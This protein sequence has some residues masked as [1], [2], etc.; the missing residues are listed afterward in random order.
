KTKKTKNTPKNNHQPY[1]Q[2]HK[3]NTTQKKQP[4]KPKHKNK[5]TKK[6]HKIINHKQITHKKKDTNKQLEVKF[7][8]KREHE[9]LRI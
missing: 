1:K 7:R 2:K 9:T 6:P 5:P 8:F 4:Q 3:P